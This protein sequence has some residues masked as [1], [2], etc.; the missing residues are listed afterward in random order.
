MEAYDPGRAYLGS[1]TLRWSFGSMLGRTDRWHREMERLV[2]RGRVRRLA[3]AGFS[4]VWIDRHGYARPSG[5]QWAEI[6]ARLAGLAGSTPEV[7]LGG[8]YSFVS[9]EA[10]RQRLERELGPEGYA[11][12]QAEIRARREGEVRPRSPRR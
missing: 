8:R 1:R 5:P 4:G 10:F 2:S 12:R 7:S 11:R 9:I 3:L 6:E